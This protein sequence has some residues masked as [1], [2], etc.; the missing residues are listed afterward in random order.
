MRVNSKCAHQVRHHLASIGLVRG[1]EGFRETVWMRRK[2]A[3]LA[4]IPTPSVRTAT[5]AVA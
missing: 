2:I 5:M 3:V 1:T 4:P